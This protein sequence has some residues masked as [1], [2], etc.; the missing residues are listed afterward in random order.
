MGVYG[1]LSVRWGAYGELSVGSGV[2][3]ELSVGWGVYE[4]LRVGWEV[5]GEL[6]NIPKLRVF[7]ILVPDTTHSFL[8]IN[9][10]EKAHTN[11]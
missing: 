4:E 2:Y 1:Y 7:G 9:S 5:Y 8:M 11:T 6:L 3:G 10:L